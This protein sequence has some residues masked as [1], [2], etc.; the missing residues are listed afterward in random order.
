MKQCN[1]WTALFLAGC[2][3]MTTACA[4]A[5]A[6]TANNDSTEQ[7]VEIENISSE[8]ESSDNEVVSE[9][10]DPYAPMEENVTITIGK[11]VSS[12][13]KLGPNSTIEDND[14]T[15]Y[16]SK[17]L[18][19]TYVD[20]WQA[21]DVQDAYKTKISIS[22]AS[23]T[24]PDVLVVDRR[25]LA[26]M[27]ES[28][29]I[30][31]LTD[32]Y[33]KYASPNLKASYESTGGYSLNSATFD[34]KLMGIPNV[35][36]GADGINLLWLRQDW[37]DELGLEAP[38]TM[39]DLE[40]IIKVFQEEKGT[41]GLL[42]NSDSIVSLG[43]NNFYGFDTIF[44]AYDAYP[45]LWYKDDKGEVIYGSVQPEV[46]TA[47][48]KLSEMYQNGL[49]DK[50]FAVKTMQQNDESV[51]SG[52][53]GIV[54]APWWYSYMFGDCM[55]QDPNADWVPYAAPV[56]IDGKMNTH[57]MAPSVNYLVVKKGFEHP[58]AVIKTVNIQHD[59]DQMNVDQ[60]KEE[61]IIVE[62]PEYQW[63]LMPFTILLSNY[64]DKEQKAIIVQSV[65][66]GKNSPDVLQGEEIQI[67]QAYLD[68]NE[69]PR[70]DF[71]KW[72]Q[73]RANIDACN[74]LNEEAINRKIGVFYDQTE[75][76]ATKWVNLKKLE[77]TTFLKII[78]GTEP[79]DSFDEFVQ[80]WYA[81]GGEEII[82]EVEAETN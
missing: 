30:E 61:G 41:L 27:V 66:D 74:L 69:N 25:Q 54:F 22:L 65:I 9:T 57:M 49:I 28:D 18:N 6:A 32:V 82:K 45:Q 39:E 77:D 13:P 73:R 33:N 12:S 36:P 72:A 40:Q 81:Q 79:I 47:L 71:Y 75:T 50:E 62:D 15:R 46:K 14:L 17:K 48:A 21:S 52:K 43:G 60:M 38:K 42:G 19:I 51:A 5:P 20:D 34:G 24:I 8:P 76:M 4:A 35:S 29:L 53:T 70:A 44:S 26:Q 3:I 63:A 7:V 2:M 56:G 59:I 23:G 67:Y 64:D 1:K 31:D 11:E 68:D 58:E 10:I 37:M 78:M 55:Q 80:K 16:L